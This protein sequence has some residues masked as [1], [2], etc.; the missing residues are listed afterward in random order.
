MEEET[1]SVHLQGQL[2]R[3]DDK[4]ALSLHPFV[5][6]SPGCRNCAQPQTSAL[7]VCACTYVYVGERGGNTCGCLYASALDF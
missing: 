4:I 5:R 7:C 1:D 3:Q 2:L 6:R